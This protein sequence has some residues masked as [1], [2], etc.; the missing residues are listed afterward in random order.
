MADESESD[1]R[2]EVASEH[3]LQQAYEQGQVPV[4]P[5]IAAAA[6]LAAV[7]LAL[8]TQG[9]AL[10]RDLVSL[11]QVVTGGLEA[12]PFATFWRLAGGCQSCV[13][14]FC[15]AVARISSPWRALNIFCA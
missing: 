4:S 1:D 8:L 12:T 5:A 9:E 6:S 10:C 14:R 3:R 2:S 13:G 11:L 15:A 7:T